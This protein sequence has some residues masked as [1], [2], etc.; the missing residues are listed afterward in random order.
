MTSERYRIIEKS[1]RNDTWGRFWNEERRYSVL[2]L[3]PC[4]RIKL[5]EYQTQDQ[6]RLIGFLDEY[7]QEF[8]KQEKKR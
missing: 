1:V 7:E 8:V 3:V 4:A 2:A 6:Q 5:L